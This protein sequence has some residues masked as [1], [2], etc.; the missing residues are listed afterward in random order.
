MKPSIKSTP[1]TR[2]AA[3]RKTLRHGAKAQLRE[4]AARRHDRPMMSELYR[5]AEAQLRKQ[6]R[7]P[8]PQ[9]DIPQPAADPLRQLHELQVHQVELELQNTELQESWDR[10]EV[11]LEKYTD[12]YDF[13]PVG[14]LSLDEQGRINEANLTAAGLLGVERSQLVQRSLLQFVGPASRADFLSFLKQVFAGT[15]KQTCTA[16][17]TKADAG[18]FWARMVGIPTVTASA[19]RKCCRLAVSDVTA[20]RRAAE[21]QDRLA[22]IVEFSDDAIIG[23]NLSGIITSWNRGAEKLFG[24]TASEI[25]GTSILRLIP[26][27]RHEEENHILDKI[28]HGKSV[29]HFETQRQGKDERLLEVSVTVSPIKD[30]NGK[31]V[32]VS[33]TVRDISRRKQ[34]EEILRRNEALF[35]ALIKQ[36]PVG[37]YVVDHQLRLQQMNLKALPV[38]C[39]VRPLIGRDFAGIMEIL[40]SKK[41]AGE[42]LGHFRHTLQ[43][44]EPYHSPEF[45]ERRHDITV[46]ETYVWQLQRVMLPSGEHGV[47]CFFDNITERKRMEETRGRLAVMTASNRKLEVEIVRRKA[48]EASLRTSEREQK[49]LLAQAQA[50]QQRLR[51]LSHDILHAQEEERKRI[52]RELHDVIA[53]T[54]SGINIR[55]AAL[56]KEAGFTSQGFDCIITRTQSLVAKSVDVVH[57]FARELRPAVLDDLGLIPA[58]RTYLNTFTAETGIRTEFTT[59]TGAEELDSNRRTVLFRVTQ[60]ALSNIVKHAKAHLVEVILQKLPDRLRLQIKDDGKSFDTELALHPKGRKGLG[61]L[62]MRERLEMVAGTFAIESAPGQGTTVRAEI[63]FAKAPGARQS[64]VKGRRKVL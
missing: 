6:K 14:Y 42:I 16:M 41:V 54:L 62:G 5:R 24:Y 15:G 39:N 45:V 18:E 27:D 64:R 56:K 59:F 11:L 20:L 28:R 33:K 31:V 3:A 58:L 40:W 44:G 35:S 1:P 52:S 29:Q 46:T 19:S 38:F 4:F 36:A 17:L 7:A 63:P 60:E 50:M 37:V 21:V 25:V 34:A 55:L 2:A 12:L 9:P 57:E 43:T 51:Q 49:R 30:E 48:I 61:L 10:M 47:V 32:G 13:A 26:A 8:Q 22:A 23:K 53:Q